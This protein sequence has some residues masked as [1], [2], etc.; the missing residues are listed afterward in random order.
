M[1]V[2]HPPLATKP[3]YLQIS[4]AAMLFVSGGAQGYPFWWVWGAVTPVSWH[5]GSTVEHLTVV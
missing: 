4:G 3:P 5:L 2:S 1:Q